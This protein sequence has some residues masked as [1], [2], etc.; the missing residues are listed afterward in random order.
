MAYT[1][2]N[3]ENAPSKKTPINDTNLNHMDDGI[4]NNDAEI[5]QIK[6]DLTEFQSATNTDIAGLFSTTN[7]LLNRIIDLESKAASAASSISTLQSKVSTI[8]TNI[9]D[10]PHWET[11]S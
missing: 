2:I 9:A 4:Y 10:V 6:S 5:T 3:W 7:D 1:K 11:A 8:E